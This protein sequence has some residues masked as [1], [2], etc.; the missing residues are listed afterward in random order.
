MK[1]SNDSLSSVLREWHVQPPPDPGFRPRVWERIRRRSSETWAAYV[2][3]HRLGWSIAAALVLFGAGLGGHIVAQVR[4]DANRE[5]MAVAYLV[6][7]DPRV[8]A[9]LRP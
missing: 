1:H 2:A 3:A 5:A 8:Q 6:E 7:L 4:L 9:M